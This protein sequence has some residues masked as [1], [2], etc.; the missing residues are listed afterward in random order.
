MSLNTCFFGLDDSISDRDFAKIILD[1]YDIASFEP[2]D[3]SDF[4]QMFG[5]SVVY[6][7]NTSHGEAV[8]VFAVMGS[9]VVNVDPQPK[10]EF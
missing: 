2:A 9:P 3:P 7:G 8:S 5:V 4:Q 6:K 1:H 10:G